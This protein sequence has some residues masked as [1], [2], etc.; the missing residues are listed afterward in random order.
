MIRKNLRTERSQR[1]RKKKKPKR[2]R[3]LRPK[4]KKNPRTAKLSHLPFV[5]LSMKNISIRRKFQGQ[6]RPDELPKPMRSQPCKIAVAANKRA[7]RRRPALHK[8]DNRRMAA[9]FARKC[10]RCDGRSRRNW[11]WLSRPP[12]F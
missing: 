3:Q 10:R 12:R 1:K 8:I 5:A 2:S 6:A 4:K 11:S 9:S 7:N